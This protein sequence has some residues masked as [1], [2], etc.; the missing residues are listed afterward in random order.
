[1]HEMR[2]LLSTLPVEQR[3]QAAYQRAAE[4]CDDDV[5]ICSAIG[6]NGHMLIADRWEKTNRKGHIL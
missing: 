5:A 1:L 6:D 3:E 4:I 2:Q